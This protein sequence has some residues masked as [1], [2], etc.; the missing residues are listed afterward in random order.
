MADLFVR[1]AGGPVAG[2]NMVTADQ[3]T[4]L[5]NGTSADPLR[6]GPSSGDEGTQFE[7]SFRSEDPVPGLP[8]FLSFISEVGGVT[9]VQPT[10]VRAEDAGVAAEFKAVAGVVKRVNDSGTVQVQTSGLLTL[11]TEEWD[12]VAESFGGLLQG[13][14]YYPSA[15]TTG[16][17]TRVPPAGPGQYV[18]RFGTAMSSTTMLLQPQ[19]PVQNLADLIFFAESP[20]PLLLGMAVYV[21]E[22]SGEVQPADQ[23]INIDRA[24]AIGLVCAFDVNNDPII[25][26]GGIVEL[27][28]EEWDLVAGGLSGPGLRRGHS[29][30]VDTDANAGHIT[31]EP[32][33]TGAKV[34][35]GI[36]LSST[37]LL[38]PGPYLERLS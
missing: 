20:T 1:Q 15:T 26:L 3:L 22:A 6:S 30:Y 17:I 11:T 36:A 4:I 38:V 16:K 7:A 13:R 2:E 25:Q 19:T 34:Q 35:V 37:R 10:D 29:Y 9:T 28:E 31:T 14:A 27:T 24:T 32:P 23:N 5:G 8:V 21:V 18:T 33:L 12:F